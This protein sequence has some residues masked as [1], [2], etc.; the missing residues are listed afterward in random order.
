MVEMSGLQL[1]SRSENSY[2]WN[3]EVMLVCTSDKYNAT[4]KKHD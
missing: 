1:M 3:G 4:E 2:S